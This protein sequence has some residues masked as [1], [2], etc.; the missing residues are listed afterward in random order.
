LN[1][2]PPGAAVSEWAHSSTRTPRLWLVAIALGCGLWMD[3]PAFADTEP[4]I[5]FL[6]AGQPGS[7]P[8]VPAD[9]LTQ[10]RKP[11]RGRVDGP[12]I[13]AQFDGPGNI[14]VDGTG[15]LY[16][17]DQYDTV[18]RKI[19]ANGTVATLAR[20]PNTRS[21]L[22]A[23]AR[24]GIVVDGG[25]TLYVSEPALNRIVKISTEGT[26]SVYAGSTQAGRRNGPAASALFSEPR[27]L[28]L[29]K[30]GNLY[31]ADA[32][33]SAIRRITPA[34]VVTTIAGS[35]PGLV[36]GP[37][38]TARFDTPS[39]LAID[40]EG[41]I[42]VGE[43]LVVN[44][45][46]RAD[47][48][49]AIRRIG[50][51]GKVITLCEDSYAGARENRVAPVPAPPWGDCSDLGPYTVIVFDSQGLL[52][53]LTADGL[54]RIDPAKPYSPDASTV[55]DVRNDPGIPWASTGGIAMDRQGNMYATDPELAGIFKATPP[56]PRA[57]RSH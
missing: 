9:M 49:G 57:L 44:D 41:N 17:L 6:W 7:A 3:V 30:A 24:A 36:D 38:S 5:W 21:A 33:N 35:Q 43:Y 46:G 55:F 39:S 1:Q 54:E 23:E 31:V 50:A 16:V 32:G 52:Y 14:A 56:Y 26:V 34:G 40:K 4:G 42:Y 10:E 19:S 29:D 18:V 45:E 20:L 37:I 2:L 48:T 27:G 25:G 53:R 47:P 13:T 51:D 28:A 8:R 22:G 12:G 11:V 15:N